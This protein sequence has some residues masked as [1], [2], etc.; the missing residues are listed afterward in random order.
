MKLRNNIIILCTLF[1]GAGILISDQFHFLNPFIL[2]VIIVLLFGYSFVR[3]KTNKSI[4]S[5]FL[6]CSVFFTIGIILHSFFISKNSKNKKYLNTI[7]ECKTIVESS[8]FSTS[9]NVKLQLKTL[10]L[11]VKDK[12]KVEEFKFLTYVKNKKIK[13]NLNDTIYLKSKLKSFEFYENPWEFD[14]GKYN[15]RKGIIGYVFLND[16]NYFVRKRGDL[17][18]DNIEIRNRL[19]VQLSNELNGQEL[20]V[21]K[22]F[23]W[24]VRDGVDDELLDAFSNTGTIHILAVSGLHVGILFAIVIQIGKLFSQ[25]ITKKQATIISI[26]IAWLYAYITGFSPSILRS[27]IVF[28]LIFLNDLTEKRRNEISLMA[29]SAMVLLIYDTNYLF[30]L[31]FQLTY[32]ALI[33]IYVFYPRFK[34]IYNVQNKLVDYFYS[35]MILGFSA[36]LTTLPI[37]LFNFHQFPN[38]FT[39]TNLLLIPF[40]FL[41]ISF[42]LVFYVFSFSS[43]IKLI[44]GKLLYLTVHLMVSIVC[45]FD[46][47]SFAVAKQF[48]F[49]K[50][51][52]LILVVILI[53]FYYTLIKRD[54]KKLMVFYL[55]SIGFCCFI[56]FK[57]YKA[58]NQSFI[59]KIGNSST[60]IAK[61]NSFICFFSMDKKQ[62]DFELKRIKKFYQ[63]YF[64]CYT[65]KSNQKVVINSVYLPFN[66][67]YRKEPKFKMLNQ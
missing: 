2:S 36:Q 10:F 52:F 25:W 47:L 14:Y 50:L 66:H 43:L 41:I 5:I 8:S 6:L 20:E 19:N 7:I 49:N 12:I 33:G 59:A 16:R 26:L 18:F 42:G 56:Q 51:D 34:S 67:V 1:L 15:E 64:K 44:F 11:N 31:G 35:P 29:L 37:I 39:I 63:S 46:K 21:C 17:S 30:D 4:S 38:Y 48:D 55:I 28:S 32:G 23:L 61:N 45:F 57:R 22:A 58:I 60:I 62:K 27:V 13:I 65:L 9:G 24:G 3:I 40:S 53:F 54:M